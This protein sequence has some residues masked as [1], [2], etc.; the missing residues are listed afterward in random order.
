MH[1][2]RKPAIEKSDLIFLLFVI[3]FL[4]LLLFKLP[5]FPIYQEGDQL[6]F[7]DDASRMLQ[8]ENIYRDFFQFTFPGT[9]LFY[10]F[11]FLIFGVKYWVLGFS[12]ILTGALSFWIC[13]RISKR[14]IDGP[15]TYLPAV[16]FAFFGLRWF[17]LD[18]SH[19][20]FSPLFILIAVWLLLR[21]GNYLHLGLAG[22]FCALSSFFTQQRGFAGLAAIV[23]FLL[24]DNYARGWKW[25]KYLTESLTVVAAFIVSLASMCAYFVANT[26]FEKFI[27][28]TLIYPTLYYKYFEHNNLQAFWFFI[29]SSFAPGARIGEFA[30]ILFYSLLVPLSIIGFFAVFWRH[31]RQHEWRFWRGPMLLGI[32]GFFLLITTSAPSAMR[33]FNISIPALILFIWILDRLN[34]FKERNRL[35]A[36]AIVAVT[37]LISIMLIVR[38]QMRRDYIEITTDRGDVRTI[39]DEKSSRYL[40]LQK[41]TKP[42]DYILETP[43]PYVYFLLGLKHASRYSQF[44]PTEYTRPEFVSGTVEC[45]EKNKPRYIVWI[46]DYNKPASQRVSGDNLGP[47][48]DYITASYDST[49]PVYPVSSDFYSEIQIW[50]RKLE[51]HADR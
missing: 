15:Y 46:N 35:V 13:L 16:I 39:S 49:G 22:L 45:L 6:I 41:H 21:S 19:R 2:E 27:D 48:S 3:T 18:G 36:R 42:G 11:L 30:P 28:A 47:L 1:S 31:R 38:F 29:K 33:L 24:A 8:G 40:W 25:K 20:V 4:Y 37:L 10:C 34:I 9:Q 23:C 5:F 50:E 14:L 17:G 26:G 43:D 12:V 32:T 44:F 51:T 7:V